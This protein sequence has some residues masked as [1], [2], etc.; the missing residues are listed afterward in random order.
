[1]SGLSLRVMNMKFMQKSSKLSDLEISREQATKASDTSEW[2]SKNNAT[3]VNKIKALRQKGNVTSVGYASI[4]NFGAGDEIESLVRGRRTFVPAEQRTS[5][6][7]QQEEKVKL[8]LNNLKE[9]LD[10]EKVCHR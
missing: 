5:A 10:D 9:S 4:Q 6:K 8:D 3:I 1:M 7:T 2:T